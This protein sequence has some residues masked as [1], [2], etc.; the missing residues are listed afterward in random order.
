MRRISVHIVWVITLLIVVSPYTLL[1]SQTAS[2]QSPV[3]NQVLS[4]AIDTIVD[5]NGFCL[6]EGST[7][8]SGS[9]GYVRIYVGNSD[10]GMPNDFNN[11]YWQ[12]W[13][14]LEAGVND[15][16]LRYIPMGAGMY[17]ISSRICVTNVKRPRVDHMVSNPNTSSQ[18]ITINWNYIWQDNTDYCSTTESRYRLYRNTI[19]SVGGPNWLLIQN[20]TPQT[21]KIDANV[22]PGTNYYYFLQVA[23]HNNLS[24][25]SKH[26]PGKMDFVNAT[27]SIDNSQA[28]FFPNN[29]GVSSRY[30]TSNTVWTV[31]SKPDW[32]TTSISN[33]QLTITASPNTGA[34]LLSSQIVLSAGT[35]QPAQVAIDVSLEPDYS[36]YDAI[37]LA[38]S[39]EVCENEVVILHDESNGVA[40]Q[41]NWIIT[42]NSFVYVDSTDANSQHPHIMM[43]DTGFYSIQLNS[44]NLLYTDTA[45]YS[46]YIRVNASP[47]LNIGPDTTIKS[48]ESIIIHSDGTWNSYLWSDN[49]TNYSITVTQHGQYWL[50]VTN[51]YSCADVDTIVIS[52]ATHGWN[53]KVYPGSTTLFGR[54]MFQNEV[55]FSGMYIGAFA[56]TEC[57][58]VGRI[59]IN[60]S[61]ESIVTIVVNGEG[62]EEIGFKLWDPNTGFIYNSIS[63]CNTL[64]GDHR[65]APPNYIPIT[66]AK[67]DLLFT[68]S[69]IGQHRILNST[70]VNLTCEIANVSE[71][72]AVDVDMVCYVSYD[73]T[74]DST[75][76]VLEE[77][78]I[79]N[80]NAGNTYIFDESLT[81]LPEF[82]ESSF[83]LFYVIDSKNINKEVDETNNI[84]SDF[85]HW[86]ADPSD[87]IDY[88]D[89]SD[90]VF[91]GG[92][93]NRD[94]SCYFESIQL[95]AGDSMNFTGTGSG[96]IYVQ[97]TVHIDSGSV[98]N[99]RQLENHPQGVLSVGNIDINISHQTYYYGQGG[100]AHGSS[101]SWGGNGGSIGGGL[102]GGVVTGYYQPPYSTNYQLVLTPGNGAG[103]IYPG[104]NGES[105]SGGYIGTFYPGGSTFMM[106]ANAGGGAAGSHGKHSENLVIAAKGNVTIN[107]TINGAGEDGGNGGA[108]GSSTG[109]YEDYPKVASKGGGGGAGGAA[110]HGSKICILTEGLVNFNAA[111]LNLGGGLG[112]NGGLG[113][114]GN[115]QSSPNAPIY[116]AESGTK[117]GN[118]NDGYIEV[119]R[120]DRYNFI[121]TADLDAMCNDSML[122][123]ADLGSD[124]S[125]QWSKNGVILMDTASL[126]WIHESGLYQVAAYDSSCSYMSDLLQVKVIQSIDLL[127]Q[128]DTLKI[129]SLIIL[130]QEI[131]TSNFIWN[132]SFEGP[133]KLITRSDLNTSPENI[134]VEASIA[135]CLV[136]DSVA[137]SIDSLV[138]Q[139][140]PLQSGW[141]L[142]SFY[143][144][145]SNINGSD[146]FG[147]VISNVDTIVQNAQIVFT[148]D[149]MNNMENYYY[150]PSNVIWI[151]CNDSDTLKINSKL[152][153]LPLNVQLYQGWNTIS[154]PLNKHQSIE[155]MTSQL[156]STLI[157]LS[158]GESSFN[159]NVP[160]GFNSLQMLRPNAGYIL[161]LNADSELTFE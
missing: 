7:S 100:S 43:S 46:S 33:N 105:K 157:E 25:A 30:I 21:Q 18:N 142:I 56:D 77:F 91:T 135:K 82:Y 9:L 39:L 26:S 74:L 102:H 28:I 73:N 110:G 147:A 152:L 67:P 64:P 78:L 145:V 61:G 49:S 131:C 156:G 8:P 88:G 103:G 134:Y 14:E 19:D 41:W 72:D 38:S 109:M 15:I 86:I 113:G 55:A 13:V 117:G 119:K 79:G 115:Q 122:V 1:L 34:T 107:G 90:G 54:V 116:R 139:E 50:E 124:F 59:K 71:G 20:W 36:V 106:Y 24:Y 154:Y 51:G 121:L 118:G 99:L 151:K 148:A 97:G 45:F 138:T 160:E 35:N 158:D 60:Q 129:D 6:I 137:I 65:G 120:L 159:P 153:E 96:I 5:D 52:E 114:F 2:I 136:R 143:V 69:Q 128:T 17:A 63:T 123:E 48:N 32:I 92:Y 132:S 11:S 62:I 44:G 81:I 125:Y 29:G 93:I 112:G 16:S 80:L 76:L 10:K 146:L 89:G 47:E 31:A 111:T 85:I 58:G 75:D 23:P 144:D 149:G 161:K 98:I 68:S 27:L 141:N 4:S 108:G 104:G 83:Y 40:T 84:S 3:D 42:P 127:D 57:R 130:N 12:K 150:S 70:P 66:F 87:C 140:I 126:R 95:S 155:F 94:S 22:V 101:Y 53:I 133:S 37:F